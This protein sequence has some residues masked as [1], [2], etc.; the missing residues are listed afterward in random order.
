VER[1]VKN[2][3]PIRESRLS[4]KIQDFFMYSSVARK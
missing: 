3:Y 2:N 1:S 4:H